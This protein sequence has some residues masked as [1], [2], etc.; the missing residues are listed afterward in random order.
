M[1]HD[2]VGRLDKNKTFEKSAIFEFPF[3]YLYQIPQINL[4]VY[5]GKI[6]ALKVTKLFSKSIQGRIQP[7]AEGGT[8]CRVGAQS[9]IVSKHAEGAGKFGAPN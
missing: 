3:V 7:E 6:N 9:T 2:S 5:L 8:A 1:P 4:V